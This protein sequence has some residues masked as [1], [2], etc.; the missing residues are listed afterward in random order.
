MNWVQQLNELNTSSTQRLV[1][2]VLMDYY[3][4]S[5]ELCCPSQKRIA[6]DTGLTSRSVIS[7]INALVDIGALRVSKKRSEKKNWDYN[8]YEL[9]MIEID[10]NSKSFKYDWSIDNDDVIDYD[11]KIHSRVNDVHTIHIAED[12]NEDVIVGFDKNSYI[13]LADGSYISEQK[14]YEEYLN[15]HK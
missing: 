5:T 12:L 15:I 2:R 4:S 7:A 6:K 9:M 11:D 10:D 3:N 13:K 1:G 8:I 14:L